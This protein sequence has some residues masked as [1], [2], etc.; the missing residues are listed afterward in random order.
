[1]DSFQN[2]LNAF[3]Q[4]ND[5]Q[6]LAV[7]RSHHME[8]EEVPFLDKYKPLKLSSYDDKGSSNLHL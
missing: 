4:E 6:D 5:L 1:M 8:W 2:S 7:I 3:V